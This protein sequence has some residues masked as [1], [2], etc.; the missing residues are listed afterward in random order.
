[1]P[2]NKLL[3]LTTSG[4]GFLVVGM[5][6]ISFKLYDFSVQNKRLKDKISLEKSIHQ[7]QI[8]EIIKRY[9]SL[10]EYREEKTALVRAETKAKVDEAVE[11]KVFFASRN[12]TKKAAVKKL[13]AV[14]VS[15]R[16]VRLISKDAVET[17][18]S[19]KIDQVR[20]RFTLEKNRDIE[21]GE[22]QIYI[23]IY[24]PK[25]RLLTIKGKFETELAEEIPYDGLNTDACMFVNLHQYQ[26]IVGD[27][28]INLL[29]KG[30]IIGSTNFRVN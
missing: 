22:K 1:M 10:R 6:I 28:K 2:Q 5:I 18:V 27:Y 24:N 8:S 21:P 26:L 23:Q 20:V 11:K 15:A 4:V 12:V 14:N 7:N 17:S 13:K 16:G 25:N 3:H 30:D 9:D 19:S 29:Y